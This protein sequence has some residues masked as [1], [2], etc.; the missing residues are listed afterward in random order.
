MDVS[1]KTS[2]IENICLTKQKLKHNW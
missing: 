2:A 1:T